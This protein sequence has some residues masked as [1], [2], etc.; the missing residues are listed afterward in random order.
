MG[1]ERELIE[2]SQTTTDL[3]HIGKQILT[4]HPPALLNSNKPYKIMSEIAK[5][6]SNYTFFNTLCYFKAGCTKFT[7]YHIYVLN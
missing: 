7:T 1:K 5:N 3:L 6:L 4:T 2:T